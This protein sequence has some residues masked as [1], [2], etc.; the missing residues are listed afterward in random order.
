MWL[1]LALFFIIIGIVMFIHKLVYKNRMQQQLGRKVN[2][3]ELTSFS[4]WMDD[5]QKPKS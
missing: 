4:A 1:L 5:D 2:D 3:R